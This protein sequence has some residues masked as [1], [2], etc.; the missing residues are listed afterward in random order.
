MKDKSFSKNLYRSHLQNVKRF[1]AELDLITQ[2]TN[3]LA[4][5]S[6]VLD[7]E[8]LL[9]KI[10]QDK[11]DVLSARFEIVQSLLKESL[12]DLRNYIEFTEDND[13]IENEDKKDTNS[14]QQVDVNYTNS[15]VFTFIP[16]PK[17]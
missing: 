13:C 1:I 16:K 6:N 2:E 8:K 5:E 14:Y 10:P 3:Q 15:N 11:V 4:L 7:D 12:S 9:Q 17:K